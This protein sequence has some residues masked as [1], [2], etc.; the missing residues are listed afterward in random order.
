[1]AATTSKINVL[2]A[3]DHSLI[4]NGISFVLEDLD[5]DFSEFQAST[6]Q[7]ALEILERETIDFAVMDAHFP[8]G[9]SLK[10]IPQIRE[11]HPQLKLLI[12]SGIEEK[13][14]ALKYMNAGANGFLSKLSEEEDIKNAILQVLNTGKYI[15]PAVQEI[16][17]SSMNNP[18]LLDPLSVLTEREL[19]IARL[20]STGLGNLEIA[21]ALDVKQNTVS[22][23]K[24]RIFEKLKI[25]NMVQLIELFKENP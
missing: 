15:S 4:R 6:L 23:L 16:L 12:Y 21:N 2:L 3:D 9:N 8:D 14:N 22:T 18:H 1:M 19:E 25:D 7:Q 13:T 20:Y 11:K 10:F 24:K 17:L 5:L